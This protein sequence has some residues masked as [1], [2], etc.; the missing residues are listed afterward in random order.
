MP[1]PLA[2]D[3]NPRP[4]ASVTHFG[5]NSVA[6][7]VILAVLLMMRAKV[8]AVKDPVF[9][10]CCAAAVPVIALDLFVLRVHRRSTTGLDWDRPF[11]IAWQRLGTK[12]VGFLATLAPFGLAYWALREYQGSFYDPFYYTLRHAGALLAALSV[13]YIAVVDAYMIEPRDAYWQ[14]GRVVLG[15]PRD[16]RGEE[17]A[18]HYR[19][20]LVK[21]YFFPLM[22]VWLNGSTHNVLSFDLTNASWANLRAYDFLYD[23]IFFIDLLLAT[24]GYALCFRPIDTHL[25]SAEPTMLGWA[26]ALFCYEPFFSGLFE[27]HYVHYGGN[28][29][30]S[31]LSPYPAFRWAWAGVILLL[32]ATY[33]LA[34]V[35]FGVRFSN[36]THRG[37]LTNGP[38]RFTKHPAYV[39]KNVSWWMASVP[40]VVSDDFPSAARR[41]LALGTLNFMYFMRAKTEE[42]HLS[43][44]PTYV[45]YALWM[46]EH[47][48]LRFLNRIPFV[49]DAI[50]YRPPANAQKPSAQTPSLTANEVGEPLA[51]P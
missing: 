26:V 17:V 44:D 28:G 2:R 21:A 29:F 16:A 50:A 38:Y 32:V 19:G 31:W 13:L 34:T 23:F 35:A 43:R 14:L 22:F 18:N 37:I 45:A 36:L 51:D 6:L 42:R 25:R 8:L 30:A 39:S 3:A 46:N 24:V 5:L 20:W 27:K 15:R 7:A 33:V 48:V 10:L 41:C 11:A 9:F 1:V 12:L 49:R 40:F 47:G 4:P